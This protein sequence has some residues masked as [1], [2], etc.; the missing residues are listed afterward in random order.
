VAV[1]FLCG[2]W[3]G[4]SWTFVVWGLYHGFFLV[5]ERTVWGDMLEKMPR[6]LRHA[7]A[8]LVV[9]MGWVLFRSNTFAGAADFFAALSGAQPAM[10][11]QSWSRYAGGEVIWALGVGTAFSL[12][13]WSSLKAA[14]HR[15]VQALP[16][17][18]RA[19]GLGLGQA[20]EILLVLGLLLISAIWL[21]GG[22]YNPF[23][24]FGF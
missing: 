16:L 23:I 12:P 19:L 20:V 24:Y 7:Y 15:L 14:G 11:A 4:A 21:A 13:L 18:A 5:L 10:Q 3:H 6:P 22:T 1:F 17:P 9:T 2:L 8:M